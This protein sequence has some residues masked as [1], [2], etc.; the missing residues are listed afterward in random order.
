MRLDGIVS[1]HEQHLHS[2]FPL[3]YFS[4]CFE[5]CD[6]VNAE[7]E[8]HPLCGRGPKAALFS[9]HCIM[10]GQRASLEDI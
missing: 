1:Q 9:A 6:K 7:C 4:I 5:I 2:A 3:G 8:L 10:S